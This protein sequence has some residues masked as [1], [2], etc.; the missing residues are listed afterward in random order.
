MQVLYRAN[1]AAPYA[2]AAGASVGEETVVYFQLRPSMHGISMTIACSRGL[3]RWTG[4]PV[5]LVLRDGLSRPLVLDPGFRLL[6][7]GGTNEEC[8]YYFSSHQGSQEW[9]IFS[10]T[11]IPQGHLNQSQIYT[12][13]LLLLGRVDDH[14]HIR[15]FQA[16]AFLPRE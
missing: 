7:S 5:A 12:A 6:F 11:V 15:H 10:A 2:H 13:F 9:G 4:P 8:Y 14:F 1:T 3:V 16:D